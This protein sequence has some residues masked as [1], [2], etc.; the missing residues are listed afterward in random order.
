MNPG[1]IFHVINAL[2]AKMTSETMVTVLRNYMCG[3]VK[4]GKHTKCK[5]SSTANIMPKY[6]LIKVGDLSYLLKD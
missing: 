1:P 4:K 6:I 2:K 3:L 5:M